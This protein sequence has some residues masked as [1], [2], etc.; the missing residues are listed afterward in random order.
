[1][2]RALPVLVGRVHR[3][4]LLSQEPADQV[5]PSGLDGF[6]KWQVV[7]I[8]LQPQVGRVLLQG[9]ESAQLTLGCTAVGRPGIGNLSLSNFL[10]TQSRLM[11]H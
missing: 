11:R 8:V 7:A 10:V 2:K 3:V 4:L 1:M 9:L 5:L 6:V